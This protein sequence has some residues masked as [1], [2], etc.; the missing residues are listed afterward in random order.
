MELQ[1]KVAGL[2]AT[3]T[4]KVSADRLKTTVVDGAAANTYIAVTGIEARHTLV[5]VVKLDFTLADG[6]PNTR[7]WAASDLLSEASV[8]SDGNIQL[9]MT[10]TSGTVLLVTFASG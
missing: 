3:Q 10:D 8:T 4:E 6:T 1:E 5:G 9:S 2:E 7:T